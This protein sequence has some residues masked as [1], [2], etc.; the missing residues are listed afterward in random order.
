[1]RPSLASQRNPC[2]IARVRFALVLLLLVSGAA[3]AANSKASALAKEAEKAYKDTRYE[4]AA[5]LLKQAYEADPN[6]KFLFNLARALD[7]AGKLEASLDAYRKYVALPSD[8]TEPDTVVK[9]NK[10]MDRIRRVLADQ[11]AEKK[12]AEAEKSR[13]ADEAKKAAEAAAREAEKSR[14]QLEAFEAK[15]RAAR[16]ES[17]KKA[18]GR[19]VGAFIAGGV[20]LAGIGVGVAFGLMANGS[21]STFNKAITVQAK[22]DA[23]GATKSQALIADVG[24][25]VG[26][27]GAVTGALLYPKGEEAQGSVSVSL[28]PT[29]GGGLMAGLG[30]RF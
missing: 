27:V 9:A 11:E 22:K 23:E 24:F 5:N 4:D 17:Q 2:N 1:M 19:K 8:E 28:G 13:L 16:E 7:Q 30:G 21:H 29:P 14:A 10:A 25:A 15:E 20:G 3:W 18:S 12:I 6:P 26:I